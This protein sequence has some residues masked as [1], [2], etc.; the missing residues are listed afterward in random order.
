VNALGHFGRPS[1]A[2]AH[3]EVVSAVMLSAS[4][5]W[6]AQADRR[7]LVV[8]EEPPPGNGLVRA[9]QYPPSGGAMSPQGRWIRRIRSS[10]H[11][12]RKSYGKDAASS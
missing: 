9:L 3:P 2:A 7:R 12:C 8:E 11:A 1:D 5:D 6:A 4:L 10:L